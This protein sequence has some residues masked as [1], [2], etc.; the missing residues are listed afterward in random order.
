[1]LPALDIS[2]SAL[3]AQRIRMNAISSN[4]ANISTTHDEAGEPSP[5]QPRFVVFQADPSVGANGAPGVKVASVQTAKLEPRLKYEPG[6][7]D[8]IKTGPNTG[9][10][11]YPNINMMTELTDA[12]EAARAYEAN[13]GTMEITKDLEQ[14]TLKI[15][16]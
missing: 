6:N 3:V 2:S 14:Q 13:L 7:P 10:V 15:L 16:A 5:Y 8:A 4:L 11:A 9:Y 1:M 12:M